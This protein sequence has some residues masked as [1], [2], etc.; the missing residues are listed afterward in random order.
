VFGPPG[1]VANIDYFDV[2]EPRR[3]DGAQLPCSLRITT[4]LPAI[5]GSIVA[6]DNSDRIYRRHHSER[7]RAGRTNRERRQ[8][9]HVPPGQT[10]DAVEAGGRRAQRPLLARTISRLSIPIILRCCRSSLL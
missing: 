4:T 10:M 1:T 2:S 8:R 9:L 5:M 7:C 6:Q 3:V